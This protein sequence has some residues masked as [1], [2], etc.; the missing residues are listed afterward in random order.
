MTNEQMTK[1]ELCEELEFG[2]ETARALAGHL[3]SMGARKGTFEVS[4]CGFNY[5]VTVKYVGKKHGNK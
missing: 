3:L 4:F 2:E 1:D 5:K